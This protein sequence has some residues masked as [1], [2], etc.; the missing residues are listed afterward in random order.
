[1]DEIIQRGYAIDTALNFHPSDFR[2]RTNIIEAMDT[3]HLNDFIKEELME[4]SAM[5]NAS[6]VEKYKR[7]SL[8]VA[9]FILTLIGVSLSSRKARGGI[10]G[11]LGAGIGISFA[12]ILFMQISNTFAINGIMPPLIAVWLPNLLFMG[13][14]LFL[15]RIAP[16]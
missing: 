16:K 12:Y 8:P 2:R 7:T 14:A 3:P 9:T 11:Q 15:L 1:M 10:G 5:V 4:G 6:Y 13:I